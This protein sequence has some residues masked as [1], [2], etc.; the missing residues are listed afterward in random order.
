MKRSKQP[1]IT[2]LERGCTTSASAQT[3]GYEDT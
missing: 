3:E 2:W 1:V